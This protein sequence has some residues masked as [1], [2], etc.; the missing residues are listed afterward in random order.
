V[1]RQQIAVL[2]AALPN[3]ELHRVDGE[4]FCRRGTTVSPG[5]GVG[6]SYRA[7][8]AEPHAAGLVEDRD[9]LLTGL[10]GPVMCDALSSEVA[11]VTEQIITEHHRRSNPEWAETKLHISYD[12]SRHLHGHSNPLRPQAA[13]APCSIVTQ[14]AGIHPDTLLM[15]RAAWRPRINVDGIDGGHVSR[16]RTI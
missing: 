11:A 6:Y 4:A 9:S 16:D 10:A 5:G 2:E 14:R 8:A 15:A 1:L 7:E 12:I 3:A 13:D